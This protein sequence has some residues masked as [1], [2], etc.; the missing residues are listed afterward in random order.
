MKTF[1]LF[2]LL[3]TSFSA[4]A[5]EHGY[6]VERSVCDEIDTS[7][8]GDACL[9]NVANREENFVIILDYDFV[10]SAYGE[11]LNEAGIIIEK[12][13]LRRATKAQIQAMGGFQKSLK[14]FTVDQ[15]FVTFAHLSDEE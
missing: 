7:V 2:F 12:K 11:D 14:V 10:M 4:A 8:I 5:A 3:L 13:G 6:W 9:I 1:A 15:S